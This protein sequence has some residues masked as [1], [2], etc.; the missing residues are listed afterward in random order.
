[1]DDWSDTEVDHDNQW[2]GEDENSDLNDDWDASSDE[3]V[4][5][6]K[7]APV[8]V[9]KKTARQLAKEKE[10]QEKKERE[11]RAAKLAA[12]TP[13]EKLAEKLRLQKLAEDSDFGITQDMFG[14]GGDDA[15]RKTLD[16]F[17]P[18]TKNEF[19]EFIEMM[20]SKFQKF[21]NSPHYFYAVDA[22]VQK[23]M[24]SLNVDDLKK[25][26]KSMTILANEKQKLEKSAG[27]KGK[28]ATKAKLGGVSK[29][30]NKDVY[31]TYDDYDNEFDDFM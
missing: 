7:A 8:H 11:E 18:S 12:Q 21:E 23:A 24:Q 16:N 19:T 13:E 4:K 22:F 10:E 1:M 27:K 20:A 15:G 29:A 25:I 28:K 2:Q 3:E 14:A 5:E 26:S 17:N 31:N 6:V 9:K 30:S